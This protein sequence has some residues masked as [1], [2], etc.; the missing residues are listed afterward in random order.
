MAKGEASLAETRIEGLRR[1]ASP[2]MA[3]PMA[4]AGIRGGT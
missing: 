3:S 2:A 4:T 1:R